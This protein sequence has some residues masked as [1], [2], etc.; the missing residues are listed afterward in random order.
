MVKDKKHL[1]VEG[2][3]Q[4]IELAYFMNIN[5]SLRSELS[6]QNLLTKLE[7]KYGKLPIFSQIKF[8]PCA[9]PLVGPLTLEFVRGLVDGDGSFNVSFRTSRR[10]IAVNFTIVDGASPP[11]SLF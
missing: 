3:I 5:T 10:R 7:I 6:K 2:T 1:T 9:P 11:L 8:P 4:I